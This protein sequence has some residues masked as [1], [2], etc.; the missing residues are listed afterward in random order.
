VIDLLPS[1]EQQQIIDGARSLL[2]DRT[3]VDRLRSVQQGDPAGDAWGELVAFGWFLFGVPEAAG[4]FGAGVV[5]EMLLAREAGRVLLPPSVLATTLAAQ[6]AAN[7]G[8]PGLAEALGSGAA[9]AGF[10][11]QPYGT[12]SDWLLLD[13]S[14]ATHLVQLG[15]A[16]R[17]LPIEAFRDRRPAPALDDATDLARARLS[18]ETDA[19]G[20]GDS[21]E[22]RAV[23]LLASG[24]VGVAEAALELAV[25]Y[26]KVREQFGRQIGGFQA[27]KH[28]CAD[29]AVRAETA[30]A[31]LAMAALAE[32]EG[33]EDSGLQLW[34]A[35]LAA[36]K[37][38]RE[39]GAACIQVHGGM[40]FTW[41]CHA[42][43]YMKRAQLLTHL[44]G[45]A[46][47]IEARLLEQSAAVL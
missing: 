10:A 45:G 44:L 13:A 36:V 47:A 15:R 19:L 20:G 24:L 3:P 34:S 22:R 16:P 23:L 31:Q 39:N 46:R 21:A 14:Q 9:R 29:M 8:S 26:A 37:A 32:A 42:H 2:A 12:T 11:V 43:R 17:L 35:A 28:R 30:G 40:G 4:G 25:E 5:E 38:A 41:E 7:A 18:R 27:I 6:I 1:E 33:L